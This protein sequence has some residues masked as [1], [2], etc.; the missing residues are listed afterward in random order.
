MSPKKYCDYRQLGLEFEGQIDECI[1]VMGRIATQT[2]PITVSTDPEDHVI[3]V[4]EYYLELAFECKRTIRE[5]GMNVDQVVEAV[6]GIFRFDDGDTT[7]NRVSVAVMRNYLSKPTI[8]RLPVWILLGICAATG[9]NA[10]L[11]TM[12]RR[13]GLAIIDSQEQLHLMLGVLNDKYREIGT[14]KRKVE[15]QIR[16]IKGRVDINKSVK[17]ETTND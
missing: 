7:A 8:N 9:N 4:N 17:E 15:K 1:E 16:L 3:D 11:A 10:P 14:A 5:A 13:L 2:A 6:N 12:A